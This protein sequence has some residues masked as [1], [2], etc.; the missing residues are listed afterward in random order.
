[1]A[2]AA[3]CP[4]GDGDRAARSPSLHS[5]TSS[6]GGEIS[7]RRPPDPLHHSLTAL[8]S[9]QALL[10]SLLWDHPLPPTRPTPTSA[11]PRFAH[12]LSAA[13]VRASPGARRCA[14][15][16]SPAPSGRRLSSSSRGGGPSTSL[17]SSTTPTASA[18]STPRSATGSSPRAPP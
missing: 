3:P 8:V 18:S 2:P 13:A 4:R 11:A 1:M 16:R 10:D 7:R 5:D 9:M 17:A 14:S 6:P 15:A 12:G